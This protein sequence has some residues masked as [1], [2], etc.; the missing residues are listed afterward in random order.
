MIKTT[1]IMPV[2]NEIKFIERTLHSIAGEADQIIISD[3]AST[4]GTSEIC[5]EFALKH[6]EIQYKRHQEN[7]GSETF[8]Y[9]LSQA[10]GEYIMLIGGHDM[11]SKNRIR[12]LS[13]L[14]DKNPDTVLAFSKT[15]HLNESYSFNSLHLAEE[16]GNDLISDSP[17][18]RVNSIVKNLCDCSILH[19]LHRTN[20]FKAVLNENMFF[21]KITS[22][23]VWLTNLAKRGKF[24]I[25]NDSTFFRMANRK[26]EKAWIVQCT[27]TV[28]T[29]R[30]LDSEESV[31]PYEWLL[32]N[33]CGTYD[34]A[35]EMQKLPD[36]PPDFDKKILNSIIKRFGKVAGIE[37]T[38]KN[39]IRIPGKE[40]LV[41][42][43]M[44]TI[45]KYSDQ[46]FKRLILKKICGAIGNKL[47]KGLK[48][49]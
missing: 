35:K 46:N 10:K 1:L 6:P 38:S 4:D 7:I 39:T 28:K 47:K 29:L 12:Q 43:V 20:E 5:Q 23:H 30:G 45:Y 17:Y 19:G 49:N 36:A 18:V 15:V 48:F 34:I 42:E 37:S 26:P 21:D 27:R 33:I 25:D 9:C 14:L 16:F 8:N 41:E 13:L 11:I 32:A 2:Y 24:I 44:A 22:D 3:N 31:N 40:E